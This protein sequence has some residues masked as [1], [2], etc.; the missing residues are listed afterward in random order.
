VV[1]RVYVPAALPPEGSS[2]G[3]SRRTLL[4]QLAQQCSG[5]QDTATAGENPKIS[6][7][8]WH[9]VHHPPL[10]AGSL[11]HSA[12]AVGDPCGQVHPEQVAC[13][14]L[15]TLFHLPPTLGAAEVHQ[16]GPKLLDARLPYTQVRSYTG[17]AMNGSLQGLR[18]HILWK[19]MM[20]LLGEGGLISKRGPNCANVLALTRPRA[21]GCVAPQ[22]GCPCLGVLVLVLTGSR[23]PF[24]RFMIHD[25]VLVSNFLDSLLIPGCIDLTQDHQGLE[26]LGNQGEMCKARPTPLP[27]HYTAY[28]PGTILLL[29]SSPQ[30]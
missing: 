30:L 2:S 28:V 22:P 16:Y 14:C 3:I 24:L 6:T 26:A 23:L 25:E 1:P 21:S 10:R 11:A 8:E 19:V 27:I 4:V 20:L 15:P 13:A 18:V 12:S 7:L 9:H 17:I 5:E 29:H